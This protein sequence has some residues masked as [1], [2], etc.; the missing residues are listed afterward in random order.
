MIIDIRQGLWTNHPQD[1]QTLGAMRKESYQGFKPFTGFVSEGWHRVRVWRVSVGA[2]YDPSSSPAG[3]SN[4]EAMPGV[5]LAV[6][7]LD[8]HA[9]PSFTMR[10]VTASLR[11]AGGA[12]LAFMGVTTESWLVDWSRLQGWSGE[13]PFRIEETP[14]YIASKISLAE[15]IRRLNTEPPS[16]PPQHQLDGLSRDQPA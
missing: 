2:V 6:Q 8:E 1:P 11:E 14:R 15:I 5:A 4:T 3:A 9:K 7:F 10:P 12:L 13:L 16:S